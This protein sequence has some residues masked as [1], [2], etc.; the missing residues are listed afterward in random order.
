MTTYSTFAVNQITIIPGENTLRTYEN[1]EDYENDLW[2]FARC[3][4]AGA[5]R[6]LLDNATDDNED[7]ESELAATSWQS[8]HEGWELEAI[9]EDERDAFIALFEKFFREQSSPLLALADEIA[10][11]P[12]WASDSTFHGDTGRGL[13]R[14][15]M[16]V[17]YMG[18]G[19]G[20]GLH[21]YWQ[22][23]TPGDWAI[24]HLTVW[25]SQN[26]GTPWEGAHYDSGEDEPFLHLA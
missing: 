7:P 18:A 9:A 12:R 10:W 24:G 15:G 5:A 19:A 26:I 16:M 22:E 21:D 2:R 23:G 6:A 1:E 14:V 20:M 3:L 8:P 13:Y 17:A 4:A 25:M 11:S